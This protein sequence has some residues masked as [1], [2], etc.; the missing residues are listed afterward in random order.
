MA[1]PTV[2]LSLGSNLGDL[3]S[4]IEKA[5]ALLKTTGV[6]V[7][8][9]SSVIETDP[10]GGPQQGK[11]LNAVLKAKT[12][13]SA[14]DLHALTQSIEC[15]MGRVRKILN[16]P[17]VIDIDI[18]LY[19]DVKLITRKLI[20]PHPRMCERNF[21]MNPLKEIAPIICQELLDANR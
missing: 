4:Y 17:R 16:G 5:V 15:K 9:L 11:Y 12:D 7:Q 1:N 6:A 8:R 20:I 13:L 14:E 10:V 2:Y 3:L 19:D 18:L 21:V